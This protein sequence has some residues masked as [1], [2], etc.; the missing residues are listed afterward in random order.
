M[1]NET[2]VEHKTA[3]GGKCKQNYVCISSKN[4]KRQQYM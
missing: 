4:R 1:R 2:V 3:I